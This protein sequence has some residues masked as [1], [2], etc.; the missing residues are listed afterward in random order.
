M[1]PAPAASWRSPGPTAHGSVGGRRQ[2]I[3]L[4]E[5]TPQRAS[6]EEAF[7]ELTR[8]AVE[9]QAPDRPAAGVHTRGAGRVTTAAPALPPVRARVTLGPDR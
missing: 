8:D 5:L 1:S 6:L 3:A 4:T 9:H 7:M 2:G